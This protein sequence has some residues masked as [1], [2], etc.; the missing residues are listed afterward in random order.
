MHADIDD[1]RS[2]PFALLPLALA[3]PDVPVILAHMPGE[4]TLDGLA[5]VAAGR[6]A[7][8]LYFDTSTC[9]SS[10]IGQAIHELG[11]DR[12]LWGSDSPWWDIEIELAKIRLLD[13]ST[14][15]AELVLGDNA[16][17]LFGLRA[18]T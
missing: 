1:P 5:T 10:M 12:I 13:L 18:L 8:N 11:A 4:Y 17:R 9:P 16:R 15:D 3:Y 6:M 7:P 14:A 2:S